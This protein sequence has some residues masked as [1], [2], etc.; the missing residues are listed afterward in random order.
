VTSRPL[1]I[2][3]AVHDPPVWTL[4]AREVERLAA[5]LPDFEVVDAR[6]A[7]ER[8]RELPAADILLVTRLSSDE[9][10]LASRLKWIQSTAVGIGPV[11]VPEVVN[12]AI[13]VTNAR[14]IHAEFIAEHAI[15]LALAVRRSLHTSSARQA[16][17]VWAQSEIEAVPCPPP[18]DSRLLVVGLGEI[19][20]RVAAMAVGLGFQVVGTRRRPELPAPPGVTV[21]SADQL[22]EELP[23]ADVVILTAPRTSETRAMIGVDELAGMKPTAVLVNVARGRLVDEDALVEALENK[24]IAGAGLDAFVREPLPDD[25]RLWRLPN[26]LISPHTAAF[27]RDYWAPAIDLFIENVGRFTRGAPLLNVVDKVHGY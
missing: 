23:R 5:A 3:A 22:A 10:K 25:H 24:Q 13:V 4:P 7:D 8:R 27:G 15:A 14:G 19:G 26:V 9:A 17:R 18:R 2:V 12:S 16:A 6:T 1:R 21:R 20:A 11:L